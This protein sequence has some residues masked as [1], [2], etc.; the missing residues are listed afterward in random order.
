MC[1]DKICFS[2]NPIRRAHAHVHAHTRQL[3]NHRG[4]S[5]L[6]L[7]H[8][9]SKVLRIFQFEGINQTWIEVWSFSS[10]ESKLKKVKQIYSHDTLCT[11]KVQEQIWWLVSGIF[12]SKTNS[13][14]WPSNFLS[15]V[16]IQPVQSEGRKARPVLKL[17]RRTAQKGF[18]RIKDDAGEGLSESGSDSWPITPRRRHKCHRFHQQEAQLL[19]TGFHK[20]SN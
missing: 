17:W 18:T 8:M 5:T 4:I 6:A 2:P 14:D 12:S 19:P 9:C 11:T 10:H 13:M 7:E 15:L 1:Y 16:P 3:C 20:K